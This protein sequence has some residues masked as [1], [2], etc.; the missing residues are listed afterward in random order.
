MDEPRSRDARIAA[1]ARRQHGLITTHQ[2]RDCGL[3][4]S[5]IAKRA[6]VGR[7]HRVQRGVYSVGHVALSR[8]G[9]WLA[10]VLAAGDGAA[11]SHLAAAT[12]WKIWKRSGAVE[13][14]V[15]APRRVRGIAEARE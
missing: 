9:V 6:R 4:D 3:T 12:L 5:S 11:L 2:L 13:T 10:A 8:E 14:T 15:V 7:L 1:H